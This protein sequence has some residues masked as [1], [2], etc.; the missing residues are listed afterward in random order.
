MDKYGRI[1]LSKYNLLDANLFTWVTCVFRERSLKLY[2]EV[3]N[4]NYFGRP[5]SG[6]RQVSG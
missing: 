3:Y 1:F 6:R 4:D 2:A 5:M